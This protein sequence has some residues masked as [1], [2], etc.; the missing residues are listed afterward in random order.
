MIDVHISVYV[1]AQLTTRQ[2]T[3]SEYGQIKLTVPRFHP[4]MNEDLSFVIPG[5]HSPNFWSIRQ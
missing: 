4:K 1:Q 5:D 3:K 2:F